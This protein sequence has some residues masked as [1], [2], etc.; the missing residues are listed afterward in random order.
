[1][2]GVIIL[3]FFL[4][5]FVTCTK[6]KSGT[7]LQE[8]AVQLV[9]P[10]IIASNIIIDSLETITIENALQDVHI[11]FST[12]GKE[13][14]TNSKK[15]K[16]PIKVKEPGTYK[17][18]A[19]HASFKP[20]ESS[21]ITFY[22]KGIIP[23]NIAWHSMENEKYTGS[24]TRTL[25]DNKKGP[26]EFRNSL[27]QGFDSI[28]SATV[29]FDKKVKIKSVNIGYLSDP[30]SWIF[31]PEEVTI[32]LSSNDAFYEKF[33]NKIEV[34]SETS[35]RT[36][37]SLNIPIGLEVSSIKIEIKNLSS[38]PY[39]HE[40]SGSKAWLFMDEWIFNEDL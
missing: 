17:F 29:F 7:F 14:N 15:Y 22:K 26:L 31:P 21:V 11:H 27:W 1:M 35:E 32:S 37:K 20:S 40:G 30:A 12:D 4:I 9:Q 38:I 10:R 16:K 3:V 33:T 36:I 13:P 39:W 24:G 19:F 5:F 25:I 8:E 2:K 18:K 34:L 6:E 23:K 28:V